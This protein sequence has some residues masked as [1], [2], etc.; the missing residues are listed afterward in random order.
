MVSLLI[1]FA[2]NVVGVWLKRPLYQ[3]LGAATIVGILL[4]GVPL[5][6]LGGILLRGL[7]GGA[8]VNM[9]LSFYTITFLQRMLQ[10][11][12]RLTQA[13]AAL[14]RLV[15][16]RRINLM[17]TPF[18]IGMMPSVGAVLIAAPIVDKLA[19]DELDRDER[20]FVSSYY[21]HI[22]EAF[23]PTYTTILLAL[24]LSGQ[25]ALPF[26]A[27][28]LPM[29]LVLFYLGHLFYVRKVSR[30]AEG[31]AT[32][33]ARRT[34]AVAL[35]RCL[36]SILLS[37]ALILVLPLPI[38]VIVVGIILANV[39]ID[40]FTWQELKPMFRSAFETKLIVNTIIIMIF[41]ELLT[42]AGV[43]DQLPQLFAGL[44]VPADLLLGLTMLVGT[45][46]AGTQAMVAVMIPLAFATPGSGL[47]LLT[48][49]MCMSYIAAQVTPTHICLSVVAEY[50]R[51]SLV[52]LVRK[53]LPVVGIFLVVA[54]G[55]YYL[56]TLIL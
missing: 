48:L 42:Y 24:Q 33:A 38:Y 56:L 36:W 16:N 9:V 23:L 55:Y 6:D 30:G 45:L 44:P 5:P 41:K 31:R 4:Y 22:S 11:R 51:S 39:F 2:V 19:G 28:M 43:L 54:V 46:I 29:V 25:Q 20:M 21:R 49:L 35:L 47:A 17:L 15:G 40:R 7:T 34:A 27:A 37:V 1:V 52:A 26:L 13:E 12:D 3:S 53:T 8:T 14:S 50:Y 18:V 10:K 32:K